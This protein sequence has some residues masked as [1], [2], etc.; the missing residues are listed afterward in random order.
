MQF[1]EVAK[2]LL[3][4]FLSEQKIVCEKT[5]EGIIALKPFGGSAEML[6]GWR[7]DRK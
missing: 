1:Q 2:A 5:S 4:C 6:L 7:T 3:D